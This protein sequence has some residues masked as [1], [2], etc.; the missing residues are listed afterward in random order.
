MFKEY[1][2][3]FFHI[4]HLLHPHMHLNLKFLEPKTIKNLTARIKFIDFRGLLHI[5]VFVKFK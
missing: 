2:Q 5:K 4:C 3:F 1:C